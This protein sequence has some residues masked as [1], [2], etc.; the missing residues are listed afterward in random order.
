ML[1]YWQSQHAKEM[2]VNASRGRRGGRTGK[3]E[4]EANIPGQEDGSRSHGGHGGARP[5][6]T[7]PQPAPQ[8]PAPPRR[9]ARRR[10]RIRNVGGWRIDADPQTL[11][12]RRG[13][14]ASRESTI[15]RSRPVEVSG[16]A[17][18]LD[19]APRRGPVPPESA[20]IGRRRR[21]RRERRQ[22]EARVTVS[23]AQ[24][25]ERERDK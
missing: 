4:R 10:H 8:H 25:R 15:S 21:R 19:C 5:S 12:C 11:G 3:R 2:D 22:R 1:V 20:G 14:T 13:S 6:Q 18:R 9:G 7:S 16:V 17:G 24:E 23:V